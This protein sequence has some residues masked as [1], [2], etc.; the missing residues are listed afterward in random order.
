VFGQTLL[1]GI[2][3]KVP[4]VQIGTDRYS[5]NVR[6]LVTVAPSGGIDVRTIHLTVAQSS[7]QA[8]AFDF[9]ASE[10][11][12]F[13]TAIDTAL[14]LKADNGKT[15][16]IN[17]QTA[18][19]S[20][21]SASIPTQV[22]GFSMNDNPDGSWFLGFKQPGFPDFSR[23]YQAASMQQFANYLHLGVSFANALP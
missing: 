13:S 21:E 16:I 2:D 10:A 11:Q 20:F 22:H 9:S 12:A 4:E 19:M 6:H 17:G 5:L 3:G 14:A 8:Q 1:Y 15:T 7:G 23:R 18:V